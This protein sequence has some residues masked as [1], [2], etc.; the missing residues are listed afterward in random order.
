MAKKNACQTQATNG[1]DAATRQNVVLICWYAQRKCR[2]FCCIE[3]DGIRI[4]NG[5]YSLALLLAASTIVYSSVPSPSPSCSVPRSHLFVDRRNAVTFSV[6]TNKST[7]CP[8]YVTGEGVHKVTQLIVSLRV[9]LLRKLYGNTINSR[10][11]RS[12]RYSFEL[13]RVRSA[14]HPHDIATASSIATELVPGAPGK[15]PWLLQVKN[16][17]HSH[18]EAIVFYN[19]ISLC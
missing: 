8:A 17:K 3:I 5:W 2:H 10:S 16:A 15:S 18:G 4:P 1:W 6:R 11:F 9:H 12:S 14:I 7:L 13:L 19:R